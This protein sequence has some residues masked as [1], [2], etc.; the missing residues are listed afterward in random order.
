MRSVMRLT[1]KGSSCICK[2]FSTVFALF[3]KELRK[4]VFWK[5]SKHSTNFFG[6]IST[7]TSSSR[8]DNKITRIIAHFIRL[9]LCGYIFK[10]SRQLCFQKELSDQVQ[11]IFYLFKL[12]TCKQKIANSVMFCAFKN[13]TLLE[14]RT[15]SNE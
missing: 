14:R 11:F 10:L 5:R 2:H 1:Y 3:M 7:R 4:V 9:L 8:L 12:Q 13:M 15:T 6:L